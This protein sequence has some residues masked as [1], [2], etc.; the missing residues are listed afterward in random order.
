MVNIPILSSL[1]W[2]PVLAGVALQ[3]LSNRQRIGNLFAWV[4]STIFFI[5]SIYCVQSFYSSV[6]IWHFQE[7]I[8][9][10]P[11]FGIKY[12][13]SI[14]AISAWLILLNNLI[15]ASIIFG[16]N[17]EYVKKNVKFMG[18][19][20]VMQGLINGTFAA[21]DGIL[22]YLFFEAMLI[23]LF[24]IIGIWGGE[25]RIYAALKFFIYTLFGSLL[26]LLAIIYLYIQSVKLGI[27]QDHA[28]SIQGF[29]NI[30]LSFEEQ[31]W[32]FI[33]IFLAFAIKVPMWPVHTWLPDA[34][35]ESPTGGSMILAAITLKIGA[36]GFYRFL[37]PI[38]PDA[39]R[40][41]SSLIIM[42]SLVAI[43]YIG[44]VAMVQKDMKKLI[45]YSSIAHMGFVTLG[46]F[47][48]L[49]AID[50]N[51][52]RSLLVSNVGI[53]GAFIQMISHGFIAS[54]LF[55]S[56]GILYDRVHTKKISDFGGV[57]N[58]MPTFAGLFVFFA[59][60]NIGLPGTS[61]FVGEFL[62]ILSSFYINPLGA[63]L[64]ALTLIIS[65]AYM[66][67]MVRKVFFGPVI[68]SNVLS[69]QDINLREK[70]LLFS[71]AIIVCVIGLY[72][73]LILESIQLPIQEFMQNISKVKIVS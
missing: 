17:F 6:E 27:N 45:A 53:D 9:W 20:L 3:A 65:A 52:S 51:D 1:V 46:F 68:H 70:T 35:V 22:F 62:V 47:A 31:K 28:F 41:Y 66:L 14:D 48:A 16:T 39:A 58:I 8:N 29:Y 4:A 40:A 54:A 12:Q 64:A 19:F 56:V 60:A 32:L 34:H 26:L 37:L 67:N 42:L 57:G 63:S 69:L 11:S 38:V 73:N 59:M 55:F 61:G 44:L 25:R 23:P 21:T 2:G 5:V 49:M 72:P 24:L 15:T 36:Y 18:A 50:V 10:L 33:A 71:F 43:I 30:P 13:L 7:E